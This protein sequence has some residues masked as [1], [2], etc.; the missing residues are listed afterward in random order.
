MLNREI[1]AQAPV[2][3]APFR[4]LVAYGVLSAV[5]LAAVRADFPSIGAAGLFPLSQLR[6]GEAFARMIGE[7]SS[8]GFGKVISDRLGLDLAGHP[9]MITVRGRCHKRDGRI[10]AD[11]RSKVATCVLYLN[12][13]WDESGGRLRMLHSATD[14]DDYAAE[15]PPDG[16]TLAAYVRTDRS[17][18][19]HRPY[20]GERRYVM[21]NWMASKAALGRELARHGLSALLKRHLLGT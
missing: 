18:H 1:I 13:V 15:V 11:S 5:D 20:V 14:L 12:D 16:G 3:T 7:L 17:W 10:H 4:F 2:A 9:L 21:L 6:Y 19:G 8:P